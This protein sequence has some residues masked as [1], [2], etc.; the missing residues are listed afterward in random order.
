MRII[1]ICAV[2]V[3]GCAEQFER[4]STGVT[5]EECVPQKSI[6]SLWTGDGASL[7]FSGMRLNTEYAVDIE[8]GGVV[9]EYVVDI[10]SDID[11][12]TSGNIFFLDSD[13]CTDLIGQSFKFSIWRNALYLSDGTAL[14]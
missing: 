9:C 6:F 3:I 14:Y 10:R 2:L 11:E 5:C 1:I 12:L 4:Q 8:L 13:E 7:D